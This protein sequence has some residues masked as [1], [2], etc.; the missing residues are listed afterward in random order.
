MNEQRENE[1][2]ALASLTISEANE[3][4]RILTNKY[5]VYWTSLK[6]NGKWFVSTCYNPNWIN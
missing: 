2:W 6:Y 5:K 4:S 1:L 3:L